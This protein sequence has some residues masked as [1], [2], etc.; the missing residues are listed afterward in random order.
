[1]SKRFM[2]GT[3]CFV[4]ILAAACGGEE[5]KAPTPRVTIQPAQGNLPQPAPVGAPAIG[6][7]Q[8]APA[9][10]VQPAPVV[11]SANLSGQTLMRG[12]APF[13]TF[14]PM[15]PQWRATASGASVDFRK[16]G[17]TYEILSGGK[18]Y[19]TKLDGE[20]IKVV[21]AAGELVL[22]LKMKPDKT[23]IYIS[24]SDPT[25]WSVKPKD[26][27]FKVRKGETEV[28]KVKLKPEKQEIQVRDSSEQTVCTMAG[29]QVLP[30][31][32]V[33]LMDN[34]SLEQQLIAFGLLSL[35]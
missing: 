35:L 18:V 11:A 9:Q 30:A 1:M 25:P 29:N 34:L 14:T 16:N 8:P 24:D 5:S 32:S 15:G 28:G 19:R 21:G 12:G 27:R 31:P 3:M 6:Q 7:P 13:I 33:C 26:G 17:L 4:V 10:P 23:K 22:K 20:K 2:P